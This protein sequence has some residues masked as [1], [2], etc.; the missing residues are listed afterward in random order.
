MM[1]YSRVYLKAAQNKQATAFEPVDEPLQSL[2]RI[3]FLLCSIIRPHADANMT[4]CMSFL[5]QEEKTDM[6]TRDERRHTDKRGTR[7]TKPSVMLVS[8]GNE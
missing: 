5:S 4:T 7:L 6:K 1:C 2:S 8:S 3:L